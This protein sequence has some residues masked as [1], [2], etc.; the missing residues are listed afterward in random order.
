[1]WKVY[2]D[3]MSKVLMNVYLA[4]MHL[5]VQILRVSFYIAVC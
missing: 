3:S 2:I 4:F 5:I 1:M